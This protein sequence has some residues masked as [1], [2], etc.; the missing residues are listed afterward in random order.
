M[1]VEDA[2][3]TEKVQNQK[4][5]SKPKGVKCFYCHKKGH[6]AKDCYKKKAYAKKQGQETANKADCIENKNT[7]YSEIALT[8]NDNSALCK[9]WWIDSGASRHMTPKKN[10]LVNFKKFEAPS[11][12]KLADNS[13]LT[14]YGK[15]DVYLTVYDGTEKVN[16][17]LKDILYVPKVQTNFC[18]CH[19]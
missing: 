9:E 6:F 13:I 19:Q 5:F 8:V 14:S 7:E 12:V 3:L 2:F 18:P 17:V 16:V 10:S 15:G 1:K 11:Q 4:K